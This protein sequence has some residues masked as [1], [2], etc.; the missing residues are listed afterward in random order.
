MSTDRGME[1]E[2]V[3]HI[4]SGVLLSHKKNEI[5]P[6][7]AM[8]MNLEIIIL[9]EVRERKISYVITY[10]WNLIKLFN[11]IFLK[12]S[13]QRCRRAKTENDTSWDYFLW[14]IVTGLNSLDYI[15]HLLFINYSMDKARSHYFWIHNEAMCW[16]YKKDEHTSKINEQTKQGVL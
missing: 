15:I 1:K 5:M 13:L 9:S 11:K 2:D 8:W 3:V 4:Y 16:S 6:F 14:E 12:E 7:T 10:M